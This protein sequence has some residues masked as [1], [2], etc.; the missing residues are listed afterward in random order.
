MK[1]EHMEFAEYILQGMTAV[2]AYQKA[3]DCSY[4]TARGSSSK[5]RHSRAVE[6]YIEKRREEM[7]QGDLVMSTEEALMLLTKIAR[8]KET[9][10]VVVYDKSLYK[11][12]RA[13]TQ[14]SVKNQLEALGML[15]KALGTDSGAEKEEKEGGVVILPEVEQGEEEGDD[16]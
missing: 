10:D 8:R 16:I 9:E 3:Y 2:R 12:Q 14:T 11:F 15:L 7:E 4:E 1:K 5:L 6:N 13:K